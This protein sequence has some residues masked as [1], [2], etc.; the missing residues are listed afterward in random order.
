M[1]GGDVLFTMGEASS[2]SSHYLSLTSEAMISNSDNDTIDNSNIDA[3]LVSTTHLNI[4]QITDVAIT[5]AN[6]ISED[7]IRPHLQRFQRDVIL[8]G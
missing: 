3:L 7:D 8:Y 5:P 6:G 2:L 4:D 1:R